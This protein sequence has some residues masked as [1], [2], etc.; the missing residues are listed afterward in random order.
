MIGHDPP[1]GGSDLSR[2][3]PRGFHDDEALLGDLLREVIA[4]AEGPGAVALL[5][6]A[7]ALGRDARLGDADAAE[8]LAALVH[9]LS[10]ERT[11]VLVR[12]LTRWFQLVNLAEDNERIRRLRGADADARAWARAAG[13]LPT[14][15]S[16]SIRE[17]VAALA[18]AGLDG[19]EVQAILDQAE[20][21]LVMT[22]HPTEA[23]RRTTIDKLAR[24]FAVLRELDEVTTADEADARRRLLAT[25]QELW[26]SDDLRAIS[27]TVTDEVRGALIHFAST[28]ADTVPRIYR[29]LEQALAENFGPGRLRVGPL[30]SFGSWIGGDRDGNPFVTPEA[31]LEALELMREQCLRLYE[32]HAERLAGRLSL[33]ERLSGHPEGLEPILAAG[34]RDFPEMA[35]RLAA[36]NP[37]EPYRRALTFVRE[38]I[39]ATQSR[40]RGAYA[41]AAE[42]LTDLRRVESCLLHGHGALTAAG[43]LH[44]VIRQVEVFGFHYARLDIREHARVHRSTL[45]EIF[46]TLGVH[47]GYAELDEHERCGLLRRHIADRRPLV[48]S[49]IGNFSAATRET[50][51]TFRMLRDTL[52]VSHRGAIETYIVS[53]TEGPGDLLEVLLL[54]KESSLARAG[55]R[56]ARLRIV[57]LFE[58]GATLE[59]APDTMATLLG[60]PEYREAL[61]AV[62]DEQEIMIGYSDSNKDVGYLGSAWA[63]YRAQ[64][65]L[66]DVLSERGVS[67]VFFH[68]RGGAVGRGGGPTNAAILA[69]PAG[70]VRA[71]L[72]MTEQGEVLTAKYAVAPI[73]H[74]ELELALG[75]TLR[76][77]AGPRHERRAAYEEI[78]AEMARESARVYRRVV[79][80]DPDFVPFFESVTPVQEIS[81]LRLGSRPARRSAAHGIEDLRAIPWV[82]SWTQ[83]RIVLPAWLGLGTAL[84]GAR[85]RHGVAL[86][87]EMQREWP[88][89]ATLLSNAE[90]GCAKA[91]PAIARRYAELWDDPRSA[92]IYAVLA[93]ELELTVGELLAVRDAERLLDRD[94]VLQASI[95]RRNP[96]VDPLS[97]IQ[98][99]L[100]RRSRAL[101]DDPPE[102]L[103]RLS[104]LTI[105]GIASGLR[106]TG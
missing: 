19:D 11:D 30:L 100:L 47:D 42:L 1:I 67:W 73:A 83:A 9:E 95:D 81:R 41:E 33:S 32:G 10:L 3:Q 101:G 74:R 7:V 5:D 8:A 92:R 75:A 72:K 85:D 35:A 64:A 105:N 6:R 60:V 66:A 39:R 82:F 96:F 17:A 18:D 99:E 44:E 52:A 31:T 43:D 36:L 86:L 91:D 25:I 84:R 50:V 53:G 79:H 57:P 2:P 27:L 16:G 97:F 40:A 88:F 21:R 46:A 13:G 69:L 22:A 15:R 48:P 77:G 23:R 78:L 56:E 38:R 12:A 94:P 106:N 14:P 93:R 102:A 55:G 71:R 80:E 58:A 76:S 70:T 87:R 90:M 54:M 104:L 45:A 98:I 29:D 63:A 34:E 62:G 89:F 49:D 61:R 24:V 28:L 20:L 68:G 65:R 59:A 51:E 37:E 4:L 26:A 103:G